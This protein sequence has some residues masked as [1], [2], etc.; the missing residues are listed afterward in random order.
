MV[1][2]GGFLLSAEHFPGVVNTIAD[3]ESWQ[4]KAS[5]EWM[6]H[7]EAFYWIQQSLGPCHIYYQAEPSAQQLDTGSHCTDS[8]TG[9]LPLLSDT[10]MPTKD[11]ART[12]NTCN[13]NNKQVKILVSYILSSST[14]VEMVLGRLLEAK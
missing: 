1:P 8:R 13:Q 11:L 7:R 9:Q 3:Q 14:I 10:E 2:T 4:I 6:L 5:A 12:E